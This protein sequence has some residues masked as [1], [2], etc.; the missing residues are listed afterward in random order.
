MPVA[1]KSKFKRNSF[2]LLH[3]IKENYIEENLSFVILLM[4][5]SLV[6]ARLK[7]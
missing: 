1:E 2:L 4:V 7:V 3:V 6:R 5:M